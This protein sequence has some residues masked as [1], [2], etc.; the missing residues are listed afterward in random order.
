M[1]VKLY[2]SCLSKNISLGR[3]S[4]LKLQLYSGNVLSLLIKKSLS[5]S[6][7]WSLDRVKAPQIGAATV[8]EVNGQSLVGHSVT[9]GTT[10]VEKR[11]SG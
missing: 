11:W 2:M 6:T 4:T 1:S 5:L 3:V 7:T 8:S 9:L 10:P